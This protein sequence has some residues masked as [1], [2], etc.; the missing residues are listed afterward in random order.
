MLLALF[1]QLWDQNL[2]D[3]GVCEDTICD[4]H[5]FHIPDIDLT[6]RNFE[7]LFGADYD[8]VAD[9]NILFKGTSAHCEVYISL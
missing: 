5:D 2:Q 1:F 9:D 4:D 7:E 6:F 3:I 8:L